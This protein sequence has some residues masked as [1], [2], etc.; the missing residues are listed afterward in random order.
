MC[1]IPSPNIMVFILS[2]LSFESFSFK[3]STVAPLLIADNVSVLL[4]KVAVYPF[5]EKST[6]NYVSFFA[7]SS[8]IFLCSS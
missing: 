8:K 1:V 3:L 7:F 2:L 5:S 6:T 4:S